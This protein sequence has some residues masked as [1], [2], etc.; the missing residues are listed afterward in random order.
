MAENGINNPAGANLT[1]KT[2]EEAESSA[3]SLMAS[4]DNLRARTSVTTALRENLPSRRN[5]GLIC[6]LPYDKKLGDIQQ[7]FISNVRTE[8]QK[9]GDIAPGVRDFLCEIA[10]PKLREIKV[11]AV[12]DIYEAEKISERFLIFIFLDFCPHVANKFLLYI[13]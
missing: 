6:Y 11:K 1:D 4:P 3:S 9:N 2:P 8:I 7:E 12:K 10:P 13:A 5:S